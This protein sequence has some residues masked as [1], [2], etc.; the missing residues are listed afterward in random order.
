MRTLQIINAKWFNATAWYGVQ[1]ASGLKKLGH[2]SH[3]VCIEN[4]GAIKVAKQHGLDVHILPLN[5]ISGLLKSLSGIH[6]LCK[7]F[8]PD[9]VNC[10]RGESFYL[11][12]LLQKKYGYH[13][14]RTR[15]DQRSPQNS[16]INRF[17]Y[18]NCADILVSTNTKMTEHLVSA[19]QIP[20]K[21]IRT[22]LGGVDTHIFFPSPDSRTQMRFKYN[23][24]DNDIVVGICGRLDPVKGHHNALKA[25]AQYIHNESA[26]KKIH[27]VIMGGDAAYNITELTD[28]ANSLFIPSNRIHF[29]GYVPDMAAAM[30]MLDYGLISSI[31]SETIARV[32][33]EMIACH[34]PIVSTNVGVM[35]DILPHEYLYD[36]MDINAL[37]QIFH[38][39]NESTY[40]EN[41]QEVCLERFYDTNHDTLY[42]WTLDMFLEKTLTLYQSILKG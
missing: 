28:F 24:H 31:G 13:L 37:E 2:E 10:H 32:A 3:V 33:F 8:K 5:T 30:N 26:Q 22:I 40:K 19:M 42:G 21:H 29:L 36:P 34:V 9:I 23:F 1:I 6:A 25:F 14:V 15:G 11:W 12:A 27:I 35:P 20:R 4:S 18:K 39:M 7:E 16:Y 38:R 17:L 41:L